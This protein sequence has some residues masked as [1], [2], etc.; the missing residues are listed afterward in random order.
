[1]TSE[2]FHRPAVD[3]PFGRLERALI[4][5]FIRARGHDPRNL[6]G[7]PEHE[8]ERLLRDASIE[9]STR[10]AEVESRSHFVHELHDGVTGIPNNPVL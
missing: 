2:T 10:L 5:E 4:D 9:A 7:L 1:M 6:S 3:A 8:R